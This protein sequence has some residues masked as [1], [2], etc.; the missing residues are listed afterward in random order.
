M[1]E[2]CIFCT[3]Q[4]THRHHLI[5]GNGLRPIAEDD[6]I[7]IPIC[8]YHHTLAPRVNERIHDNVMAEKLSKMLGQVIWEK[9]AVAA[10]MDEDEAREAFR[11]RY[12]KCYYTDY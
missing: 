7:Y 12:G 2:L 8:E 9:K 1:I 4:A 10:G 11:K 3:K 5:F 6:S